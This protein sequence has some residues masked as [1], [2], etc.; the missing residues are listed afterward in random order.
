MSIEE[1]L[2]L[3]NKVVHKD[4]SK[5][6]LGTI[7]GIN[8]LELNLHLHDIVEKELVDKYQECL[9]RLEDG[10]PIQYALK[11]VN[12]YGLDF[13]VD[14]RVLIPRFETEELVFNT[15]YYINKYFSSK[16]KV[17]DLGTGSGCIGLTLKNLNKNLDVTL[18][19]ISKKSLEVARLNAGNLHLDVNIIES[20]LF[21]NIN[22]KF[23]VIISNPPYVAFDDEI[24][25]IVLRNEPK[26][27]LFAG[28]DGLEYYEKILAECENYL[29]SKFMI[30]FEIGCNQK[31][32]VLEIINK[33]LKDV[34]VI[35]KKDMSGR[36]RMIFIFK[37]VLITE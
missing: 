37:N 15:N 23:D 8:P 2:C 32:K 28:N 33:Y 14:E 9:K 11:N 16:A 17:L 21:S 29:S 13:Y 4:T 12:F 22:S 34:K 31:E 36:D 3:G 26:T 7:L 27:A 20:D 24:S 5:L 6:L 35:C 25:E 19:D 10:E 30:S 1:L 18:S